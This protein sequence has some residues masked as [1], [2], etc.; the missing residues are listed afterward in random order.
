MHNLLILL[1]NGKEIKF[2][3]EKY[4]TTRSNLNGALIDLYFKGGTGDCP[5]YLS[6]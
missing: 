5:V 6:V 4:A 3:C 2:K 1:K